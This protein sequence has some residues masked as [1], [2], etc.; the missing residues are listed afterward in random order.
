MQTFLWTII[1]GQ[2]VQDYGNV[3]YVE[4]VLQLYICILW[5]AGLVNKCCI[6]VDIVAKNE[7]QIFTSWS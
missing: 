3:P 1:L 6:F 7:V 2:I 4:M 5:E